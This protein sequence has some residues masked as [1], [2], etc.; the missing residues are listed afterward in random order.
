MVPASSILALFAL[1][2]VFGGGFIGVLASGVEARLLANAGSTSDV[3]IVAGSSDPTHV[4]SYSP[5]TLAVKVGAT[6]TWVN[7][8]TVTHTV[9]SQGRS[10]FDSGNLPTGATFSFRFTQIGTYPYY[11]TIHPWMKGTVVVAGS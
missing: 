1:G 3:T 6:V 11:C 2:F 4:H 10:L 5:G 8:D 7:K 9:T